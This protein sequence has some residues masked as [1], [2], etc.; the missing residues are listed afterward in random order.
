MINH[1]K[2]KGHI[3]KLISI[4]KNIIQDAVKLF[5]EMNK[6]REYADFTQDAKDRKTLEAKTAAKEARIKYCEELTEIIS[7][8]EVAE[9]ENAAYFDPADARI[10]GA[11]ELINSI[12]NAADDKLCESIVKTFKGYYLALRYLKSL[13]EKN[14]LSTGAIDGVLIDVN[15]MAQEFYILIRNVQNEG[16]TDVASAF[17]LANTA[18]DLADKLGIELSAGEKDLGMDYGSYLN[19]VRYPSMGTTAQV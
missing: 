10:L 11:A 7:S 4:C 13:F 6:I 8:V 14:G 15:S 17:N 2:T 5:E 18:I 12:G 3:V 1:D 9:A 19:I 16:E